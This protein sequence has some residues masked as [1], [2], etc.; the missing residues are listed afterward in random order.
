MNKYYQDWEDLVKEKIK[1]EN[2]E[3]VEVNEEHENIHNLEEY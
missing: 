1:K 2:K 3:E